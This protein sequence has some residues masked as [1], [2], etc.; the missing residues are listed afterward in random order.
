METRL[1]RICDTLI[2]AG[3]LIALIV[4]PLF[5][6]TY[7]SRV[8]EPDKLHLLR[9][10]ALLVAVV[11]IIQLLD[12][13]WQRSGGDKVSL[14]TRIRG[15]P[16]VLPALVLVA[17]YLIS[18]IFSL[19]PRISFLG[20]YVRLQGT[21]SFLSYVI[22]F[23]AVLTHLRTRAQLNRMFHAIILTSVPICLY[24]MLQHYGL[25]PLPWGGDV[26]E[27]VAGN[28]GNAI[29]V[30]A[31]LIMAFFLTVERLVESVAAIL[32]DD[33][34]HDVLRALVYMFILGLQVIT[35]IFTQS[36]GP[37][38]GW[39][40]GIYV[41]CMLGLRLLGRW[42]KVNPRAPGW[43][44]RAVRP[45]Y[46]GLIGLT[47]AG[48]ALLAGASTV[49]EHRKRGAQLALLD[50]RLRYAAEHGCDLAMMGAAPGSASQRNAERHGFRIA[51][52]RIKW[53]QGP[54]AI[55]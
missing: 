55:T 52:T 26:Q 7:S 4:T 46:F 37:W 20:S 9:S 38:L 11:W 51:Y 50:A 16:L 15:T 32:S 36:R 40:A 34:F 49:P 21:Y 17:A 2:E 18:T 6:N 30:A 24:G 44:Q 1:S 48:V 41:F 31:Y 33:R 3:W 28:M 25:D 14:W 53:R 43:L 29:F 5:F 23:G 47:V 27:R 35:I 42:G 8:F 22:L 39:F 12:G 13:G 54:L 19:V 10:I 45:A